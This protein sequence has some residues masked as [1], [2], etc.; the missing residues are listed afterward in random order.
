MLL[1]RLAFSWS[2]L[3]PHLGPLALFYP[4]LTVYACGLRLLLYSA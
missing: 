3:E 4:M 1:S 2:L